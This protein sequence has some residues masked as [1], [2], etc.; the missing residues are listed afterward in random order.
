MTAGGQPGDRRRRILFVNEN[1]GGHR[2]M[3]MHIATALQGDRHVDA[4]FLDVPQPG[5]L[6][7]IAAAQIPGLARRDL[8][9]QPLRYQ[10]AQSAWVRSRL[11]RRARSFDVLHM[12]TQNT[13][14]LSTRL[15]RN[16]PTVISTDATGASGAYLLP[17]RYPT[18]HTASRVRALRHFENRVLRSATIVVAQSEWAATSLHDDYGIPRERIRIIPF[19]IMIPDL[20]P[21]IDP[22]G[23]PEVTFT[24]TSLSR[25]GG[26]ILL[27]AFD[28]HMRGRV[29]LNL[30]TRDKVDP[31]PGVTVHSDLVP[32]DPRLGQI[33]ARTAV[34]AFPSTID[35]FGYAVLE[36]MAAGV[37]VVAA[38]TAARPEI[39]T[40]GET[41][42]L[43]PA[44]AAAFAEAILRLIDDERTRV[45]MGDAG[46]RRAEEHF[47]AR[48]TTEALLTAIDEAVTLFHNPT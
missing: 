27:D 38:S 39:V 4:T 22:P 47:D 6:R 14:L 16:R 12:Y 34:F 42:L 9:L 13:A 31:R 7:R 45:R 48:L 5:P 28:R 36:A 29:A 8:D 35:T 40:D 41:G 15:V 2:S 25:K 26:D 10:L 20:V 21:R 46:R 44:D 19:G 32:G 3:H 24:G 18:A 37:A 11:A 30:I 43:V 33:L 23:L 1:I 17:Y